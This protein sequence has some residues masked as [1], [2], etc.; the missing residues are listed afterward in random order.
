MQCYLDDLRESEVETAL[1][2][3]SNYDHGSEE[4]ELMAQR[5][6]PENMEGAQAKLKEEAD[7]LTA[8]D[9]IADASPLSTA[10]SG[11]VSWYSMPCSE[12][13]IEIPPTL[14]LGGIRVADS[15]ECLHRLPYVELCPVENF[16]NP[17][18]RLICKGITSSEKDS[19]EDNYEC[20]Y[21]SDGPSETKVTMSNMDAASE[22]DGQ[23]VA[24]VLIKVDEALL[25]VEE[26]IT[27]EAIFTK[28][29]PVQIEA[30][31]TRSNR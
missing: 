4:K 21:Y 24:I 9:I 31:R 26:F 8:Y 20:S 12:T 18:V 13:E 17:N 16:D 22:N 1:E 19:D 6:S 10:L 11:S 30:R 27:K 25:F 23:L 5:R 14:Y 28:T 7:L 2:A 15:L 3:L 29:E